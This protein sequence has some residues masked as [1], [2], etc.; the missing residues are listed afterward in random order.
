MFFVH[1]I[2]SASV[3][4]FLLEREGREKREWRGARRRRRRRMGRRPAIRCEKA[5]GG[6]KDTNQC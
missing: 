3:R 5:I 6:I 1:A 2:N 4:Q